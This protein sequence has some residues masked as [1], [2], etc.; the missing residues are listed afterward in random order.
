MDF[1]YLTFE[2]HI[3][4]VSNH[5]HVYNCC[6]YVCDLTLMIHLLL[7]ILQIFYLNKNCIGTSITHIFQDPILRDTSVDPTPQV[8]VSDMITNY[9]SSILVGVGIGENTDNMVIL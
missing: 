4:K 7:Y 2:R 9:R 3:L 1:A 6:R 5:W 8:C